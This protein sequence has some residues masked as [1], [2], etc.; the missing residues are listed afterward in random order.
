MP[1]L[2]LFDIDGTLVLTGGAGG[3]AMARAFRDVFLVDDAFRGIAMSG[4]M[5]PHIVADAAARSGILLDGPGLSR[6]RHRY[7]E[8]LLEEMARPS[9]RKGVLPGVPRLLDALHTRRDVF[10]ALLTG[11]YTDAARIKLEYF[12]LWRHFSCGAY[13][14]EAPQRN[15]LVRV[16]IG[17]VRGCGAP[18]AAL[19][20]AVVVGDT[21]LD[22]A[23]A[24][25]AGAIALAVATGGHSTQEL[26]DSG[27]D[28]VFDDLSDTRRF[29]D[30]LDTGFRAPRP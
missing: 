1:H 29:L 17:R 19:D 14:E 5:D 18:A 6:F 3:R 9:P 28:V 7:R 11:N 15:Q 22:V 23:C 21:P 30:L 13:G 20:R 8:C 12:D 27:A 16:A 25:S 26:A 24:H 10:L 2:I 4:R